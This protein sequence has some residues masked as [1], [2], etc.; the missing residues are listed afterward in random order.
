[1]VRKTKEDALVTRNSILDAAS[2]LF[3][4]NGVSGTTLQHIATA[5]GVTRGAIYWHFIDKGALFDAMM[6]RAKMPFESAM[7]LLDKQD[8]DDP[9]GDIRAY[10][11]TVFR[12]TMEDENA[13]RAFEIATLKIEYTGEMAV[14]RERRAQSQADWLLRVE[15]KVRTG[16]RVGQIKAGIK[17]KVVALGLWVMVEGLIRTWVMGHDFNLMKMGADIVDTHL[18]AL[19]A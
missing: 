1:M 14:L 9:L 11:T 7:A 12:I 8:G 2:A 18:E 13:R 17:P 5:A 4:E 10:A 15:G 16:I 3:A 19:R 6:E